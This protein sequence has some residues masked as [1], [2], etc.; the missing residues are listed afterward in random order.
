[1][2][3]EAGH[4]LDLVRD[5]GVAKLLIGF[6]HPIARGPAEV[7]QAMAL[8]TECG[9]ALAAAQQLG[10]NACEVFQRVALG[11]CESSRLCIHHAQSAELCAAEFQRHAGIEADAH[12]ARHEWIAGESGVG[13]R[14]VHF[15]HRVAED[16][17][18]AEGHVARRLTHAETVDSL[19]PLARLIDE[20]DERERAAGDV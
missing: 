18:R 3:R 7:E 6:P 8:I 16:G 10:C 13:Q 17:V 4:H 14:V 12:V 11:F 1:M 5:P 9:H 20:A 15:E 2:G 19:E